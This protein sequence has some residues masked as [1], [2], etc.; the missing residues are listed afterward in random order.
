MCN[1]MQFAEILVLSNHKEIKL[2]QNLMPGIGIVLPFSSKRTRDAYIKVIEKT[3]GIRPTHK[4]NDEYVRRALYGYGRSRSILNFSAAN[5]LEKLGNPTAAM[6]LE[7]DSPGS[8][9]TQAIEIFGAQGIGARKIDAGSIEIGI[10]PDFMYFVLV[11]GGVPI[12]FWPN[13]PDPKVI[14]KMAKPELWSNDEL[15]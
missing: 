13:N 14:E 10:E 5:V 2:E 7:V 12:L 1:I 4:R 8:A 9:A 3:S 6:T 15:D 11:T